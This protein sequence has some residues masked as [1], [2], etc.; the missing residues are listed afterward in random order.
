MLTVVIADAARSDHATSVAGER[1]MKGS[2]DW[3]FD[4]AGP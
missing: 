3:F 2:W 4:R 1:A